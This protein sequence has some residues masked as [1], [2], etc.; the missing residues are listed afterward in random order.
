MALSRM[1]ALKVIVLFGAV[2]IVVDALLEEVGMCVDV[3]EVVPVV[4]LVVVDVTE[5]PLV[6]EVWS[7]AMLVVS[8]VVCTVLLSVWVSV[9]E[10]VVSVVV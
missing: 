3:V 9:V 10:T 6:V 7:G 4:E 5:E 8:V 2:V 1:V